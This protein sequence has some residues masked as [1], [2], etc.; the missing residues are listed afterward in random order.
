DHVLAG[1]GRC[2][3]RVATRPAAGRPCGPGAPGVAAWATICGVRPRPG[4]G[5]ARVD[6]R[7][8]GAWT[9]AARRERGARTGVLHGWPGCRVR[10]ANV[11]DRPGAVRSRATAA[12]GPAQRIDAAGGRAAGTAKGHRYAAAGVGAAADD[13]P[14]ADRGRRA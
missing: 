14:R 1:G 5:P 9:D 13:G 2:D 11:A 4:A 12:N 8:T 10:R 7:S 6:G 3:A